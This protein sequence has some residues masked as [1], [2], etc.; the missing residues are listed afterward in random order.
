VKPLQS[1][2]DIVWKYCL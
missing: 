1:E 2:A